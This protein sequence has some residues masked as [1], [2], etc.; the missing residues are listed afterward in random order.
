MMIRPDRA[1]RAAR[2]LVVD[3]EPAN[4]A[5]LRSV[6]VGSGFENISTTQ[7]PQSVIPMHQEG[8]FDLILLDLRMPVMDGF[9]VMEAL[10]PLHSADYLP[11][12]VLTAQSDRETRRR[13]LS[14]G[15]RDFIIKPFAVDEVIL[16][17]RN[18]LE[19]RLLHQSLEDRVAAR[20]SELTQS[21]REVLHRLGRA[22]EYRDNETGAHVMRMAHSCRLLALAAGLEESHADLI[23][24]AS[25]MHDIGKIGV[26]DAVL[27]K[28]GRLNA[29]EWAVMQ[30]HVA[31][32]GEILSDP[33]SDLLKLARVIALTHHEKFDGSGYPY[34]L[35]GE[36][37]PI[38]GRIAAICD[39]FDALTSSRPYKEAWSVEDAAGFLRDNAGAFH[40]PRLVGLFLDLVPD[41]VALRDVYQD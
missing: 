6:L 30:T 39:V 18:Q 40:D 27:L 31:I 29:D 21:Q 3:D 33:R 12:I 2:I 13:A 37:I 35:K 36:D 25:Q 41:V 14:M 23:Y 38:E 15:A 26:P 8:R 32:S 28:P 11:V 34:G 4:V 9:A 7:D 20:T 24:Q 16:R 10:A 1:T 22:G 5:L 19:M 17:V